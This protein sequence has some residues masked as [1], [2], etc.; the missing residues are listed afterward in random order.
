MSEEADNI[1]DRGMAAEA[2]FDM[3]VAGIRQSCGAGKGQ[4]EIVSNHDMTAETARLGALLAGGNRE[5]ILAES[6]MPYRCATC[7]RTFEY[8]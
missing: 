6:D 5:D 7:G 8:P 4:C 3:M 1:W 2:E